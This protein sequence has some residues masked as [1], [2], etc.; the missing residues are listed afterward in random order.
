M[1]IEAGGWL[2]VTN[3]DDVY[4]ISQRDFED[5]YRIVEEQPKV[6]L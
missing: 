6:T 1:N 3:L 2:N 4:G 5:T